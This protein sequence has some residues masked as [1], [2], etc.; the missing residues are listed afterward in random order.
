MNEERTGSGNKWNIF[1][2][3]WH[4]HFVTFHEGLHGIIILFTA[5]KGASHVRCNCTKWDSWCLISHPFIYSLNMKTIPI[6][7]FS[8]HKK[9][10]PFIYSI[11]M[12]TISIHI[13]EVRYPFTFIH[14]AVIADSFISRN[15]QKS[16]LSC[17]VMKNKKKPSTCL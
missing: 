9:G 3:I 8:A 2:V 1:V 10:N 15:E 17:R 11:G 5:Q 12:K 4:R 13:F 6:H 7:I 14:Y 16:Q